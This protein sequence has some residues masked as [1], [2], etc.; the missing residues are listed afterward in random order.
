[1]GTVT[2]NIDDHV[3][4]QF[5]QAALEVYGARKGYLGQATTDALKNWVEQ[6]KQKKIAT[7]ELKRLDEGYHFGKKLYATREELHG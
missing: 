5:R 6:R 1:M 3:E 2:I 7:R 4:D